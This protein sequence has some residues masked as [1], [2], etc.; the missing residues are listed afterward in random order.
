MSSCGDTTEKSNKV[1]VICDAELLSNDST[2]FVPN[3]RF[4][5][6]IFTNGRTQSFDEAH[7]GKFSCK[8]DAKRPFGFT[9]TISK[10]KEN[11]VFNFSVWRLSK[12]KPNTGVLII[13]CENKP[14]KF[15][16]QANE[17]VEK[18]PY[19]WEKIT[20]ELKIPKELI[21]ENIVAY[22]WNPDAEAVVYFDDFVISYPIAE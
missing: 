17:V 1:E 9:Y 16:A 2:T 7:T 4:V 6:E 8:L 18:E 12:T 21:G 13:A 10:V 11:D 5:S 22:V 19:G 14:E 20:F 3:K 15:Y